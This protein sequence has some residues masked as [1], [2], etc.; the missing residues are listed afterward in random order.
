[1][2]CLIF[3]ADDFGGDADIVAIVGRAD[4]WPRLAR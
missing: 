3:A 4:I 1:M 2:S